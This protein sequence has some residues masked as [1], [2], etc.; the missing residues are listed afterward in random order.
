LCDAAAPRGARFGG[1]E[2][3]SKRRQLVQALAE[4][5]FRAAGDATGL[6]DPILAGRLDFR[7][8]CVSTSLRRSEHAPP[9]RA[10]GED[11]L[12]L[13]VHGPDGLRALTGESEPAPADPRA[14]N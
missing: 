2:R 8:A 1:E 9:L 14:A 13:H 4:E 6:F 11:V 5:A 7:A 10:T 3:R 12:H